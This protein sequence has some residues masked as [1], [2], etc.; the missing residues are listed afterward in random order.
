MKQQNRMIICDTVYIRTKFNKIS[1]IFYV[2]RPILFIAEW[3]AESEEKMK[4][5]N[6]AGRWVDLFLYDDIRLRVR[7][8]G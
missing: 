8:L 1:N 4:T 6:T 7:R 3:T 2:R 5:E